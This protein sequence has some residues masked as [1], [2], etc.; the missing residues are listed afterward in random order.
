M[1][2]W[3]C[4][5]VTSHRHPNCNG[6]A[7]LVGRMLKALVDFAHLKPTDTQ[8]PPDSVLERP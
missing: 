3:L 4:P 5:F 7:E 6:M 2:T 8:P 1:W